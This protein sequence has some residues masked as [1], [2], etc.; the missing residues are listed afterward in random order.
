MLNHFQFSLTNTLK[1]IIYLY[2]IYTHI[3]TYIYLYR[4]IYKIGKMN[5]KNEQMTVIFI[6]IKW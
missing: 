4:D 1:K 2:I 3:Y 6:C 5:D